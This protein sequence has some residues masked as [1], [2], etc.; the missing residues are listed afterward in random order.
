MGAEL[1]DQGSSI[2]WPGQLSYAAA[3]AGWRSGRTGEQDADGGQVR[4]DLVLADVGVAGACG[5]RAGSAGMAV[6]APVG[7]TSPAGPRRESPG[8]CTMRRRPAG[9]TPTAPDLNRQRA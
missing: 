1:V 4:Q 6:A 8:G 3:A 9:E 7:G 5:V 2:D